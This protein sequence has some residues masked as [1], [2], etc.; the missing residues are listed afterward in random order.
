MHTVRATREQYE[1]KILPA[2]FCNQFMREKIE[3]SCRLLAYVCGQFM[4]KE[5][6][7]NKAEVYNL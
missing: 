4:K 5:K 3:Q 2:Y 6:K 7:K 1:N